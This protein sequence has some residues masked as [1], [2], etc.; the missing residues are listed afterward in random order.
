MSDE[1]I[2]AS[3]RNQLAKPRSDSE[4]ISMMEAERGRFERIHR[5]L[6]AWSTRNG[7]FRD[8][9]H[10]LADLESCISR[11]KVIEG[12]LLERLMETST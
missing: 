1:S 12:F 5:N 6:E 8:V 2:D 4:L 9:D 7:C 10:Y 3:I 11:V